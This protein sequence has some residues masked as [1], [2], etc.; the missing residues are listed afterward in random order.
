MTGS[1]DQYKLMLGFWL[2]SICYVRPRKAVISGWV[3]VLH[4]ILFSPD[5]YAIWYLANQQRA[6]KNQKPLLLGSCCLGQVILL[7]VNICDS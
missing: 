7:G 4:C 3:G 5:M 2:I 6:A 1:D